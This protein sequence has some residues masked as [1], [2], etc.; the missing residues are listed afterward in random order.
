MRLLA[1]TL[2]VSLS[3][4]ADSLSPSL[5]VEARGSGVALL[6]SGTADIPRDLA[7]RDPVVHVEFLFVPLSVG[8]DVQIG[9]WGIRLGD[10]GATPGRE[11]SLGFTRARLVPDAVVDPETGRFEP[12]RIEA[13]PFPVAGAFA[14]LYRARVHLDPARQ[15]LKLR[16]SGLP[17]L[18]ATADAR[19]GDPAT[20]GEQ[21]RRVRLEIEADAVAARGYLRDMR[22]LWES[23]RGG[24]ANDARWVEARE[25][26]RGRLDLVEQRN[27][28]RPAHD[29]VEFQPPARLALGEALAAI[30]GLSRAV[31]GLLMKDP[32]ARPLSDPAADAADLLAERALIRLETV[33]RRERPRPDSGAAD[34]ALAELRDAAGE[35]R[36]WHAFWG[37]RKAGY[38]AAEWEGYRAVRTS[39]LAEAL[40]ALGRAAPPS[41]YVDV[42]TVAR[43]L[44]AGVS[45]PGAPQKSLFEAYGGRISGEIAAPLDAEWV[46]ACE[47]EIEE[48]LSRIERSLKQE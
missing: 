17:R 2:V 15:N 37:A 40:L 44:L 46:E 48:R 16:G 3:S 12:S 8:R 10:V 14:G 18:R 27:A 6:L 22:E 13:D 28:R 9:P 21:R 23:F 34:R 25:A 31:D 4:F 36:E 1:F 29:V 38:E 24:P 41:A 42:A 45:A 11:V 33:I 35:L 5:E 47:R 32:G 19:F 43:R 39:S 7:F 30:D 20:F 26:F